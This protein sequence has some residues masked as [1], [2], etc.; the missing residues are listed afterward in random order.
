L[1]LS[2]ADCQPP[3]PAGP[4]WRRPGALASG[5][6]LIEVTTLADS[7]LSRAWLADRVCVPVGVGQL[8]RRVAACVAT[9]RPAESHRWPSAPFADRVAAVTDAGMGTCAACDAAET[10][11]VFAGLALAGYGAVWVDCRSAD[12][13]TPGG[14][15]I[16]VGAAGWFQSAVVFGPVEASNRNGWR[17]CVS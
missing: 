17:C 6:P 4:C 13:D 7:A 10:H 1:P 3:V 2:C 9:V 16:R 11:A 14:R 5:G 8:T 15:L 12:H